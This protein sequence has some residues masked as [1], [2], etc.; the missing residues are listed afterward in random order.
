[1]GDLR[2]AS[3]VED[4]DRLG[5]EEVTDAPT[6]RSKAEKPCKIFLIF[7]GDCPKP[8]EKKDPK[9]DAF[10]A[11]CG[12][13][14]KA[15]GPKTKMVFQAPASTNQALYSPRGLIAE[16]ESTRDPIFLFQMCNLV[17]TPALENAES[18]HDWTWDGE[19][20]IRADGTTVEDDTLVEEGYLVKVWT[21]ERVFG[22]R[23]E[24]DLYRHSRS[25]NFPNGWRT[26][27]VCAEGKL[28]TLLIQHW[29]PE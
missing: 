8:G 27:C 29:E 13:T 14:L 12:H 25:Y 17:R 3:G 20:L 24:S 21:T 9:S 6:P 16:K 10:C 15:H 19:H 22:T 7:T 5:G 4:I 26:Y 11:T 1:L 2:L 18:D 23:E 28:A